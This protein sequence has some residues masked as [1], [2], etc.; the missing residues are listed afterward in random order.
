M[1]D[2]LITS[3]ALLQRVRELITSARRSAARAVDTLQVATN[4]EIGHL[5]VEHEQG[6]DERAAYGK[7]LIEELSAALTEEF[8]RGFSRSNLEYM[9]RFYIAYQVRGQI[10]QTPSGILLVPVDGSKSQTVSAISSPR[11][12][13]HR[14]RDQTPGR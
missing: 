5:I 10:P 8:G 9:R 12:R 6:G 3:Q 4:F 1:S 2:A 14:L 11:L 7:A 13:R